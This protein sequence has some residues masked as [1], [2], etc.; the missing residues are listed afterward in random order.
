MNI[1]QNFPKEM[2]NEENL[3][4]L[5]SIEGLS[6]QIKMLRELLP[7][8]NEALKNKLKSAK[9]SFIKKLESNPETP[10]SYIDLIGELYQ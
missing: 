10:K 2:M 4:L 3:P 7:N 6:T 1:L 5:I 9:S 8:E